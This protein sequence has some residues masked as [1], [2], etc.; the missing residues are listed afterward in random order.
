MIIEFKNGEK[1]ITHPSGVVSV[2]TKA[3]MKSLRDSV[4]EQLNQ[5]NADLIA[6]NFDLTEITN[7]IGG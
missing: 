6:Y 3:D 7:S 2:Q 5:L 1:I 4:Q